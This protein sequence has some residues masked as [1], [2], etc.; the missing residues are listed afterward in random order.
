MLPF[1]LIVSPHL[2][3]LTENNYSTVMYGLKRTDSIE[4]S[5]LNHLVQ[6]ITF[7][8]K[9]IGILIP[10]FIMTFFLNNKFKVKT[11]LKDNKFIFLLIIN[12]VPLVLVF[13]TS[14]ILGSK[15]RTMWMTPFYMFLGLFIV[16]ISQTSI[17]KNKLKSFVV[18]FLI[19]FI[20]SPFAYSYVSISKTD[21]RTDYQGKKIAKI[22]DKEW[23]EYSKGEFKL[24]AVIGDEWVAGNL[25]YHIKSRPK[26]YSFSQNPGKLKGGLIIANHPDI[27][28]DN[29]F[30]AV[31]KVVK[32]NLEGNSCFVMFK[33]RD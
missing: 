10:L 9:Q 24:Q 30:T 22:I 33:N 1:L 26:W 6:P 28:C 5:S 3:W 18:S 7:F 11:N 4:Q 29:E 12:F 25:S 31:F 27:N 19:F 16:Y 14:I 17:N 21:K 32:L 15:I 8:I 20:F 2:I 13:L 23:K